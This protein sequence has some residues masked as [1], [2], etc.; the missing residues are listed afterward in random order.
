MTLSRS[1]GFAAAYVVVNLGH[2]ERVQH[3]GVAHVGA[4]RRVLVLPEGLLVLDLK[5]IAHRSH[6][7]P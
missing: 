6:G 3:L 1:V 2:V 5:R 7:Q 4:H